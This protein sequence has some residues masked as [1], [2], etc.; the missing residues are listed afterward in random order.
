MLPTP[1]DMRQILIIALFTAWMRSGGRGPGKGAGPGV[2]DIGWV[3]GLGGA[4]LCAFISLMVAFFLTATI[5][6]LLFRR[7]RAR[8]AQTT[9]EAQRTP[10]AASVPRSGF[11]E[12]QAPPKVRAVPQAAKPPPI[13]RPS[14]VPW[15]ETRNR[16]RMGYVDPT[17]AQ[18]IGPTFLT[19]HR[20][21]GG[22]ARVTSAVDGRAGLIDR[23]GTTVLGFDFDYIEPFAD[24][25][26]KVNL[27]G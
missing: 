13:P 19:A 15:A 21:D 26:A 3:I 12:A 25:R 8:A 10:G 27:G 4:A 14:P 2:P 24:D 16:L 23:A 22:V 20:F 17:G 6:T 7:R 9:L 1:N 5:A 18:V 11:P